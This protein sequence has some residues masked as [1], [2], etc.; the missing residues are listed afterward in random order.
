MEQQLEPYD[1]LLE[2]SVDKCRESVA[3]ARKDAFA[4][5]AEC[6]RVA[7]ADTRKL[8]DPDVIDRMWVLLREADDETLE[9]WTAYRVE[10][11]ERFKSTRPSGGAA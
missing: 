8:R 6:F 3:L 11:L 2:R 1:V 10:R 4:L 7:L 9:L 5:S